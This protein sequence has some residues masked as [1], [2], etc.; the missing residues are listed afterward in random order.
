MHRKSGHKKL[1]HHKGHVYEVGRHLGKLESH[2]DHS[3]DRKEHKEHKR[4]ATHKKSTSNHRV[5]RH[6]KQRY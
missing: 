5:S 6:H 1:I 4:K 2:S 3:E